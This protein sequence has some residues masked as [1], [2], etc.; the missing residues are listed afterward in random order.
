MRSTPSLRRFPNVAFET[1][2][3]LSKCPV[4]QKEDFAS[5]QYSQRKTLPVS[6]TVKEDF[7]KR[8]VKGDVPTAA[9]TGRWKYSNA[10]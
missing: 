8:Q 3:E 6:S 1:A 5:V 7:P 2:T 4:E 10:P 9:H